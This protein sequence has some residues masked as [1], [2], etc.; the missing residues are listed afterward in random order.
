[1]ENEDIGSIYTVLKYGS[2]KEKKSVYIKF[3]TDEKLIDEFLKNARSSD[4]LDRIAI[5]KAAAYVQSKKFLGPVMG[6]LSDE[7]KYVRQAACDALGEMGYKEAI[8]YLTKEMY[9]DDSFIV[10]TRAAVA[11]YKL[12]EEKGVKMLLENFNFGEPMKTEP[13]VQEALNEL[14]IDPFSKKNKKKK[15][16]VVTACEG[17]NSPVVESLS[18]W[19][20]YTLSKTLYGSLLISLYNIMGPIFAKIIAKSD[21]LRYA[22]RHLL[23][24]PVFHVVSKYLND[25]DDRF[26]AF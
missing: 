19:R 24:M 15:C 8:P 18:I 14:K 3:G 16:F 7:N 21:V 17:E 13:A 12:G 9:S 2:D 6:F 26:K 11:L 5:A 4:Y 10:W 25:Y 23:I 20:D 1:M 22:I